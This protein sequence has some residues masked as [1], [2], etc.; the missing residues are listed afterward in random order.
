MVIKTSLAY[1]K[2]FHFY[3]GAYNNNYVYLELE[4]VPYDAGYRRVMIAIPIDIWET[5]RGLGGANLGL[6]NAT[7]EE[8]IRLIERSVAERIAQYEAARISD[9]EAAERQRFHD[10]M[11]FGAADEPRDRQ[12]AR[13]IE[14]YKTERERQR[15]VMTRIAQHKIIDIDNNSSESKSEK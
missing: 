15:G 10:S 12:L 14:Y 5:I 2:N 13:G 11:I 7:D 9:P 1:G 3:Q 4:D 8:L 6:V